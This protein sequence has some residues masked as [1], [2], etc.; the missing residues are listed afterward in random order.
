M[1]Y[2]VDAVSKKRLGKDYVLKDGDVIKIVSASR[3]K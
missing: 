2:A 3:P 1:L